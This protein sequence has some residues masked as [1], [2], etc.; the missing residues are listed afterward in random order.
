MDGASV[1][2]I[3][4]AKWL[5]NTDFPASRRSSDQPC[6]QFEIRLNIVTTC[7]KFCRLSGGNLIKHIFPSRIREA[8][9]FF[10]MPPTSCCA[11]VSPLNFW[12]VFKSGKA[13]S[14]GHYQN[15]AC[16]GVSP[17]AASC[18]LILVTSGCPWPKATVK[19]PV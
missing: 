8:I 5:L 2:S 7:Q 18:T 10:I 1:R 3:H 13:L 16:T 6:N 14:Q 9:S 11:S 12:Q 19:P 15:G 4:Q 17:R